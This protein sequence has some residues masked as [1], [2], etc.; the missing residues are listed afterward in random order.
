MI[1]CGGWEVSR[2]PHCELL[3]DMRSGQAAGV[4]LVCD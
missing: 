2:L 4:R 1:G 3:L